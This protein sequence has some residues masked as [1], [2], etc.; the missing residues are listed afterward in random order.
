MKRVLVAA[1]NWG[2][3][4]ATRCM[5]LIDSLL[6]NGFEV[7]IASDGAALRL[8]QAS[9]PTLRV[10]ELPSYGIAY[11]TENMFLNI[12]RLMPGILSAVNKE[13]KV[14]SR[15]REEQKLDIV[16]SDNRYGCYA[17]GCTNIFITHQINIQTGSK[18]IDR[19]VRRI[20]KS[21]IARFDQ[22]WIPDVDN[23]DSLSGNLSHEFGKISI[24]YSYIGLISRFKNCQE[25]PRQGVLVILSGPEP[26]RT[27]FEQQVMEQ[28][29]QLGERVTIVRGVVEGSVS[30][31]EI[32]NLTIY[33][34]ADGPLLNEL[35]CSSEVVVARSGY[36][37]L[38]DLAITGSKALL[39]PTPGQTEQIY[40]AKHLANRGVFVFQEQKSLHL[41][42]GIAEA[43]KAAKPD[44]PTENQL[45]NLVKTLY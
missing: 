1:L 23:E 45:D 3:G 17:A 43:K 9:Y 37:T 10:F 20:N 36:S 28:A 21:R 2:L 41:E 24:P 33:N 18:I 8:L 5:P 39:L 19:K 15:I 31:S 25:S 22:L 38:M 11:R 34:Y 14:I 13:N 27:I 30:K 29:I 40:L 16:I 12:F 4:H 7:M 6:E 44:F 32:N 26:Q 42:K 35:I